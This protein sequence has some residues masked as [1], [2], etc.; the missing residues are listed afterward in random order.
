MANLGILSRRYS[1][2]STYYTISNYAPIR[3]HEL[4]GFLPELQEFAQKLRK[5]TKNNVQFYSMGAGSRRIGITRSN[6][7]VF[8]AIV[9]YYHG[10]FHTVG[11]NVMVGKNKWQDCVWS[12]EKRTK[13]VSSAVN[14]VAKLPHYSDK[15]LIQHV[16][17]D[18]LRKTTRLLDRKLTGTKRAADEFYD[19]LNSW[20]GGDA[21]KEVLELMLA[22]DQ[23]NPVTPHAESKLWG[24]LAKYKESVAKARDD[25]GDFNDKRIMF[26]GKLVGSEDVFMGVESNQQITGLVRL[27]SADKLPIELLRGIS[28]INTLA[29]DDP[30]ATEAETEAGT[31]I[32]IAGFL[33][34][35]YGVYVD[36]DFATELY[37]NNSWMCVYDN[38]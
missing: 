3:I 26:V 31:Y 27:G 16:A 18:V 25:E 30:T 21:R 12:D 23:G 37:N 1:V 29:G 36:K 17:H 32:K 11:P 14:T 10:D 22:I 34:Y 28:T 19:G 8:I 5:R 4:D 2:N 13:N 20:G 24:M 9:E 38:H 7:K 33:E 6:S 15:E 35:A